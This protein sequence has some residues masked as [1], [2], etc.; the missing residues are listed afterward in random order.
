MIPLPTGIMSMLLPQFITPVLS[1]LKGEGE[2]SPT[3]VRFAAFLQA[4]CEDEKTTKLF[5]QKLWDYLV[6]SG[7]SQD[8]LVSGLEKVGPLIGVPLEVD[9]PLEDYLLQTARTIASNILAR[10][11]EIMPETKSCPV[12]SAPAQS[13]DGVIYTCY[14][15]SPKRHFI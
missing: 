1:A 6:S 11:D 2:L 4:V 10:A 5:L 15:C 12:C 13:D 7:V 8:A 9:T 3:A 14:A